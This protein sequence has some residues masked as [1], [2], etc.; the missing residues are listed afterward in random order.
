MSS[1]SPGM[2]LD[3]FKGYP[4]EFTNITTV[5]SEVGYIVPKTELELQFGPSEIP[6]TFKD[7]IGDISYVKDNVSEKKS[8]FI[9]WV[10]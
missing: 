6:M 5:T 10:K 4:I 7:A 2:C 3:G 8:S 9:E 1:P